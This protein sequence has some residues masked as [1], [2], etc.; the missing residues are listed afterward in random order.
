[1]IIAE[2]LFN[3]FSIGYN[4]FL[5]VF[6]AGNKLEYYQ[7]KQATIGSSVSLVSFNFYVLAFIQLSF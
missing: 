4:G 1:V 7:K 2:I 5:V 6:I 3:L